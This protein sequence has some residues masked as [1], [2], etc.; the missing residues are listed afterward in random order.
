MENSLVVSAK[1]AKSGGGSGIKQ[2]HSSSFT[3][4][5]SQ[6]YGKKKPSHGGKQQS[7]GANSGTKGDNN[8]FST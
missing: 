7:S 1:N 2:H 3:G 5:K 8:Q 6:N 4:Q